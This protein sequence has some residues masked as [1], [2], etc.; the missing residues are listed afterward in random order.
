MPIKN[1]RIRLLWVVAGVVFPIFVLG[2][3]L[4]GPA[5]KLFGQVTIAPKPSLFYAYYR[6]NYN[7]SHLKHWLASNWDKCCHMMVVGLLWIFSIKH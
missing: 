7:L 5:A 6:T 2:E 4:N 3:T 1:R